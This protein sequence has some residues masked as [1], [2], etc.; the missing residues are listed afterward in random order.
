MRSAS[1][2]EIAQSWQDAYGK[3]NVPLYETSD[4]VRYGPDLRPPYYEGSQGV[5]SQ[6]LVR[7]PT[8]FDRVRTL[9]V[10][11]PPSAIDVSRM[12]SSTGIAV[13]NQ[14]GRLYGP[15]KN[16]LVLDIDGTRLLLYSPEAYNGVAEELVR[17]AETLVPV[18][19]R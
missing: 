2:S 11:G 7:R 1:R 14:R 15:D 3:M 12:G 17:L 5:V 19:K 10:Q 6:A 4:V 9:I 8:N 16:R 13:G 18:A